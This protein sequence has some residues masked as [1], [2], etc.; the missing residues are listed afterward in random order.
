MTNAVLEWVD[1][2]RGV[3]VAVA[4]SAALVIEVM[5]RTGG[6]TGSMLLGTALPLAVALFAVAGTRSYRPRRLVARPDENTFDV[7]VHPG[8]VLAAAGYT[9][10]GTR[11]L[12]MAGDNVIVL[13]FWIVALAV[14]W[15]F[16]LGRFGVRLRPEGIADVH[17]LGSSVIPWEALGAPATAGNP[18]QL[19]L[20]LAR[21]ELVARHGARHFDPTRLTTTGI[22]AAFLAAV[23]E[24][25]RA[26]PGRRSAIGT[27]YEL[28]R[29]TA[30]HGVRSGGL[31]QP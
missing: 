23:I 29:L 16:A 1:R 3:V 27:E 26:Q 17:L 24:E 15:L 22:D 21:P 18:H 13:V 14:L 4:L 20:D 8:T 10:L 30:V 9:V 28:S 31:P 6:G 7:P 19:R 11:T 2:R 5:R 25:Y 12:G